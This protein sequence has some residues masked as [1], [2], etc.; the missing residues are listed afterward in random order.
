MSLRVS[1]EEYVSLL[2]KTGKGHSDTPPKG[3][4]KRN[5]FGA[6]P[7]TA[8]GYKFDSKGEAERYAHLVMQERA[9]LIW[10][11]R[12]Q[13]RYKLLVNKLLVTTYVADF[14][15]YEESQRVIEDFKGVRTPEYRLKAKLF[16]ALTGITIRETH[17]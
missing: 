16:R 4:A 5:K 17:K 15:Y 14:V 10:S 13:I 7:T 2:A 1:D 12:R 3:S 9:G 8:H 11:L 6:V